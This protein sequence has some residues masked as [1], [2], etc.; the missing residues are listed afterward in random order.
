MSSAT[1]L[2]FKRYDLRRPIVSA[3][4]YVSKKKPLSL[5]NYEV[6]VVKRAT[7][8]ALGDALGISVLIHWHELSSLRDF[9]PSTSH[10]VNHEH[11]EVLKATFK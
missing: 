8:D 1:T 3:C 11:E 9:T 2:D 5:A 4:R 6:N 10:V 7:A